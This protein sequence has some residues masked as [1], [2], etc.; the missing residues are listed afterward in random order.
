MRISL[1]LTTLLWASYGLADRSTLQVPQLTKARKRDNN[2]RAVRTIYGED[3]RR[4]ARDVNPRLQDLARASAVAIH[5]TTLP[6]PLPKTGAVELP[7]VPAR[8]RYGMCSD[9]PFAN[10][11]APGICSGFL[12]GPDLLATAAHCL[13]ADTVCGDEV[14]AFGFSADAEGVAPKTLPARQ[15]HTC[16]RVVRYDAQR[17]FALVQL[18]RPVE[19]VRPL[20]VREA[21][22]ITAGEPVG[23]VG[24][25]LGLPT[26]VALDGKVL[27]GDGKHFI[28]SVDSFVNNSGS[29]VF[30]AESLKV[31]GI[32]IAG[33]R[34]FVYDPAAECE[35]LARCDS[36][37]CL[38]EQVVRVT[39]IPEL[40]D[41]PAVLHAAAT[42]DER[43]VRE[44]LLAGGW[45]DLS[46][47]DRNSLLHHAY[48]G[49]HEEIAQLLLMAGADDERRNSRGERPSE[50]RIQ[51][52]SMSDWN[53]PIPPV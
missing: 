37:S 23:I 29:A 39:Q 27:S 11:T 36:G 12:V 9:E 53:F 26:K 7:G 38:G 34:D 50:T 52:P 5:M 18:D 31:E 22:N 24:H 8:M 41:G 20:Q 30:H 33:D 13:S 32:L 44:Y 14:W 16:R 10:Q 25:P 2:F 35:R 28:A 47:A 46:D 49:Q 4:E 19:G 40:R 43:T 1:F 15:F 45:V 21:G 17:D 48:R 3:D 51:L 42:G 6:F